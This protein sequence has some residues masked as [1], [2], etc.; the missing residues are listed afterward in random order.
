MIVFCSL[1]CSNENFVDT[2]LYVHDDIPLEEVKHA[3]HSSELRTRL[4]SK[5]GENN[6]AESFGCS[7][8]IQSQ[9][10]D[11]QEKNLVLLS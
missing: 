2:M 1:P 8:E 7:W 5:T 4:T 6:Q 3:L 10:E 9:Q 11:I